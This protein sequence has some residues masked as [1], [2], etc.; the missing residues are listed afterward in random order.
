[1]QKTKVLHIIDTLTIGGAE[2]LLVGTINDL[3]EF[4]HHLIYLTGS[5]ALL[6]ELNVH[7]RVFKLNART[8]LGFL[9]S[10]FFIRRYLKKHKIGIVHSHLCLA[11]VIAR[12]ACPANVKL[13]STIH[14]LPSKSYFKSSKLLKWMEKFTYRSRHHIVAICQEVFD[15]YD[16]C[17]GVKGPYTILNN[18][19][20]DKYFQPAFKPMSYN[21]TLR[22]IAVGNLKYQKN[23]PYLIE[24]F[25]NLPRSIHLD[26]YG[27]G[28]L[29]YHLQSDIDR[30]NLSNIRLCG[31][32]HDIEKVLLNYDALI[33]SSHYEGQ[34]LAVLEAMA[35]GIPVILSDI[36]VLH[37]VTNDQA[38]F[39]D[40]NDPADLEK[41]L[42]SLA[43]HEID[44]DVIAAANFK[45]AKRIAKKEN[46]MVALRNMYLT[47]E[48]QKAPM[49][50]PAE[51]AKHIPLRRALN[52][53]LLMTIA[54]DLLFSFS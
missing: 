23:Y 9:K 20:E 48:A 24:V 49:Q 15:D 40:I 34:P 13:F 28:D 37:E 25:K 53:L 8:K 11:T 43:N 39:F 14:N 26:I 19:V 41:K 17:I 29:A 42:R 46:Y 31:I 1:L 32:R 18:F 45:R 7:C 27:S 30:Y 4:E 21:G 33:M 5:D 2:K 44:L 16:R 38:L 22:L 35:S 6:S 52:F 3:P 51:K 54:T 12:M 47:G 36:P 50:Y 10:V